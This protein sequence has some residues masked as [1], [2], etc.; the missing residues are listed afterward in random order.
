MD[1]TITMQAELRSIRKRAGLTQVALAGRLACSPKRIA[2]VEGGSRRPNLDLIRL[3]AEACGRRFAYSF[4]PRDSDPAIERSVTALRSAPMEA[5][6]AV[7]E[8]LDEAG[9]AEEHALEALE[10]LVGAWR[11]ALRSPQR[12]GGA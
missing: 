8:I 6:R 3:W 4:G 5:Q 9:L 11:K 12:R 7:A 10:S 1:D 2:N